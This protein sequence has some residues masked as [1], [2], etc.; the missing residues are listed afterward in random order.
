[1]LGTKPSPCLMLPR[2]QLLCLLFCSHTP[3]RQNL[4]LA[5]SPPSSAS[6][7]CFNSACELHCARKEL[8]GSGWKLSILGGIR[9]SNICEG[10]T[11]PTG[12][13]LS[14]TALMKLVGESQVIEIQPAKETWNAKSVIGLWLCK[15]VKSY[16]LLQFAGLQKKNGSKEIPS[17]AGFRPC[18]PVCALHE[19][20]PGEEWS[21]SCSGHPHWPR[22]ARIERFFQGRENPGIQREPN[23]ENPRESKGKSRNPRK[24]QG[25]PFKNFWVCKF[26][27][28]KLGPTFSSPTPSISLFR[29]DPASQSQSR[30]PC[31]FMVRRNS[32]TLGKRKER[33]RISCQQPVVWNLIEEL[34]DPRFQFRSQQCL[35]RFVAE[36]GNEFHEMTEV[37]S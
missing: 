22:Q 9:V 1:M 11:C 7:P 2:R 13:D 34:H 15:S 23:W 37:F 29:G 10:L 28:P 20:L 25:K 36:I 5:L 30:H 8:E 26:S 31:T 17:S 3:V 18:T 32:Q 33:T 6:A 16:H 21:H 27:V 24:I 4:G 14:P 19:K 35:C 12:G